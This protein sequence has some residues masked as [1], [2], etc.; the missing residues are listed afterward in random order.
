M[1]LT[2]VQ[3]LTSCSLTFDL[4]LRHENI[5]AWRGAMADLAGKENDFFHNHD[6]AL[7][8]GNTF[9]HRYPLIQY[10]VHGQHAALFGINQGADALAAMSKKGLFQHF[11]INGHARPITV[12]RESRERSFPLIFSKDHTLNPYRIYRYL[13]FTSENYHAYKN[14]SSLSEKIPFLER[15]MRNHI[16]SFVHGVGWSL[17]ND[18][19]VNVVI[20]DIDRVKKTNV[21]GVNMVAFDMVFSVN[22]KLP[23][24]LGIGRKPAFGFGWTIPLP[25]KE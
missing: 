17:D 12:I 21:L 9:K 20:N 22:I 14:L 23:E 13:P 15:L 6:S 8:E 19:K 10:R 5:Q 3:T 4:P 1:Q 11:K 25:K 24:G 2:K 18:E 16:V 7:D